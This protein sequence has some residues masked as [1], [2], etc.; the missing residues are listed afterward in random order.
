VISRGRRIEPGLVLGVQEALN[1]EVGA[2]PV[3][4]DVPVQNPL[5]AST[6]EYRAAN[7]ATARNARLWARAFGDEYLYPIHAGSLD[8]LREA[9]DLL[10]Q[11]HPDVEAV[12]LGSLAPLS[13]RRPGVVLRL[14]AEARNLLRD[15]WLHVFGVGNGLLAALGLLG[16]ADS[17]DTASHIVDARYGMARHPR[18]LSMTVVASRR[19]SPKRPTALPEEIA[20]GCGCLICKTRPEKLALW[21]REGHLA[22]AIHNAH[23]I[24]I[25]AALPSVART[26]A[27]KRPSLARILEEADKHLE[28]VWCIVSCGKR[29]SSGMKPA[30]LQY[31][32][33]YFRALMLSAWA[34]CG[35]RVLV[36]SSKYGL[37]HPQEAIEPYDA[38]PGKNGSVTLEEVKTWLARFGI[39]QERVILLAGRQHSRLLGRREGWA[40]P[41][42]RLLSRLAGAE[43]AGKELNKD[44]RDQLLSL[45][46]ELRR[47]E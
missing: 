25:A 14:V 21:G 29:K 36:L 5:D 27:G 20:E 17:V 15:K 44:K 42:G 7:R 33:K 4:L 41:L 13:A 46:Q 16:L 12:G 19:E 31:K 8:T 35:S 10:M 43:Q 9:V 3:L 37:L 11:T 28:G 1:D 30:S 39:P 2:Y 23:W 40:L 18:T 34:T 26:L 45:I 24:L 47:S 22:R 32:G 38:L 6:S